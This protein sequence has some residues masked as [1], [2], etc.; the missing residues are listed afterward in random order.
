MSNVV[1]R[2]LENLAAKSHPLLKEVEKRFAVK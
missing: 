2:K 1:V